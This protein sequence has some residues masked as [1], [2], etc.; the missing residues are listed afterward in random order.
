MSKLKLADKIIRNQEPDECLADY[1]QGNNYKGIY[2]GDDSEKRY[3]ESG[4]HFGYRDLFKR[5][6]DLTKKLTPS[7]VGSAERKDKSNPKGK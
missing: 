4:A 1:N 7:R 2:F 6:S 5:L 3:F